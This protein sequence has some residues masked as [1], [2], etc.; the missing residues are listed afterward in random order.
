MNKT[1]TIL[2]HWSQEQKVFDKNL[3]ILKKKPGKAKAILD[4]RVAVKKFTAYLHLYALLYPKTGSLRGGVEQMLSNTSELYEI[5]GRHRDVEI[6]IEL[7]DKF[8][9]E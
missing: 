8:K 9:K 6:C 5:I 4:L 3:S 7:I 1:N 2:F